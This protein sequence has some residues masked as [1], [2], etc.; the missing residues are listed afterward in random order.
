MSPIEKKRM[1]VN[2]ANVRAGRLAN[3]LKIDELCEAIDRIKKDIQI[4]ADKEVELEQAL[5][6]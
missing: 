6:G 5:K 3:E 1:E 2:L 4:A